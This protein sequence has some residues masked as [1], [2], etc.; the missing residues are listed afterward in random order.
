LFCFGNHV[1]AE[2]SANNRAALRQRAAEALERGQVL[3]AQFDLRDIVGDAI[4][5]MRK[6]AKQD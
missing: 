1:E 3:A 2:V 4:D 6:D 5:E